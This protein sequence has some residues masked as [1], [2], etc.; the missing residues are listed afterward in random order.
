MWI[1]WNSQTQKQETTLKLWG[2]AWEEEFGPKL[3]LTWSNSWKTSHMHVNRLECRRQLWNYEG[4]YGKEKF[5]PELCLIW[6]NSWKGILKLRNRRQLW[7]YEGLYGKRNLT[8]SCVLY[9][10]TP[11][12]RACETIGILKTQEQPCRFEEECLMCPCLYL[13]YQITTSSELPSLVE[14]VLNYSVLSII[15]RTPLMSIEQGTRM[16]KAENSW[17]SAEVPA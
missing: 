15:S 8:Q 6:S 11:G 1:A 5:G 3:C 10:V 9:K 7:N 12:Q 14:L 13:D 2:F 16:D 4:L 17:C